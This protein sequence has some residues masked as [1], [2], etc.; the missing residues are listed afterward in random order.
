MVGQVNADILKYINLQ[1]Q[2]KTDIVIDKEERNIINK[3]IKELRKVIKKGEYIND[4]EDYKLLIDYFYNEK[5]N[6]LIINNLYLYK[7]IH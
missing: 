6:K 5:S 1:N 2:V 3:Q 4:F 7:K